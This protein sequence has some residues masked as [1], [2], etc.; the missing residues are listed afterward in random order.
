MARIAFLVAAAVLLGCSSNG[1]KG[2][3]G[4]GGSG[5]SGNGDGADPCNQSLAQTTACES[6]FA[7]QV[8]ANPCDQATATQAMCANGKYQ[9]WTMVLVGGQ[10]CVYDTSNAGALVGARTCGGAPAQCADG[11][12]NFGIAPTQYKTCGTETDACPP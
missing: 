5:G 7:M 10:T 11:C 8:A 9:V 4:G 2:G 12:T 1:S 6:T 3:D